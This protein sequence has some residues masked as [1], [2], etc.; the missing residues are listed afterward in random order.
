MG[1]ISVCHEHRVPPS[2]RWSKT[3]RLAIRAAVCLVLF[4]LP[5]A[6]SLNS[7]HLIGT[8]LG[9]STCVLFAELFGK[10]CRN[11]PFIGERK[12]C[13][14][15]YFCRCTKKDLERAGVV[16]EKTERRSAEVLKLGVREKTGALDIQD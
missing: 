3:T 12:G 14:V 8:T 16:E 4:L 13:S 15:R 6:T 9:L 10:S 2:L 7:L 11:D 5:L 1:V